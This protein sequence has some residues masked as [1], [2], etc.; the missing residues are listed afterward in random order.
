MGD[1]ITQRLVLRGQPCLLNMQ[2][3]VV[4]PQLVNDGKGF[5]YLIPK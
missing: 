3:F 5:L 1:T 4:C 2:R